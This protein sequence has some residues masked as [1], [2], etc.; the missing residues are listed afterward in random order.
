[1]RINQ[2]RGVVNDRPIDTT[3]VAPAESEAPLLPIHQPKSIDYIQSHLNDQNTV[4]AGNLS[5]YEQG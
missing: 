5:P 1:V 2:Y 4:P 3:V